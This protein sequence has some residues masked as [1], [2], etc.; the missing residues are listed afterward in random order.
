M[1]R[2]LAAAVLLLAGLAG[3]QEPDVP[4]RPLRFAEKNKQLVVSATFPEI[5]SGDLLEQ[6]SSGFAQTVFVRLYVYPEGEDLPVWFTAATYRAV[7]A[8]WDEVYLVRIRDPLGERNVTEATRA[9]ALADVT[10]LRELPVCPLATLDPKKTYFVGVIVEV[11]PVTPELVAEVRK[12]LTR[13]RGGQV[14]TDSLFGSFVSIFA[15][16]K[17]PEADQT[18]RFRSQ[19]FIHR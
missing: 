13:P 9:A 3:A 16:P 15:N 7:Y 18:L 19:G 11:N 6:L 10:T 5:F 1:T 17:V 4:I 2:R 12:W 14:G 8:Q